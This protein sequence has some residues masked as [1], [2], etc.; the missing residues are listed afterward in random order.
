ME[1]VENKINIAWTLSAG[2]TLTSATNRN[3]MVSWII[4]LDFYLVMYLL[5]ISKSDIWIL[6]CMLRG[7][8]A[9]KKIYKWSIIYYLPKSL[10]QFMDTFAVTPEKCY[11]CNLR[12][13]D[14]VMLNADGTHRLC[15][16][17]WD[18]LPPPKQVIKIQ[19]SFANFLHMSPWYPIYAVIMHQSDVSK[20]FTS[21]LRE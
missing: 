15:W 17:W 4:R 16:Y 2:E 14:T 20:A 18:L 10:R 7:R 21:D 9:A 12:T 6:I 5:P 19:L 13:Y 11:K 3:E 8:F 1:K